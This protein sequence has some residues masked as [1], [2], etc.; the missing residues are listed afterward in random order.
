MTITIIYIIWL[1][2]CSILAYLESGSRKVRKIQN[3]ES[4]DDLCLEVGQKGYNEAKKRERKFK[5]FRYLCLAS[6]YLF[7]PLLLLSPILLFTGLDFND[8][9][10]IDLLPWI[11]GGFVVSGLIWQYCIDAV[12]LSAG[13]IESKRLDKIGDLR[14]KD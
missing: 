10:S 5:H 1:I 12:N 11:F 6:A 14:R 9:G 3:A 8:L 4:L 2:A 13:E 7:S